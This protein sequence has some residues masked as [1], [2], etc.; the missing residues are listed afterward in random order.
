MIEVA[1]VLLP[2]IGALIAGLFGRL[3]G[4]RGAQ[5]VTCSLLGLSA[6]L[7]MVIFQDIALAGNT[8]V[9]EIFTWI[10]SGNLELSW[11]VKLD[12]LSAVMLLN[13]LAEKEGD[14]RCRES[15]ARIRQAYDAALRM[16]ERTRD[17]GGELSTE[18][19]TDALVARL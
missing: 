16:G 4:D 10:D 5:I 15:A 3:I 14:E 19:F 8:R 7:S 17:I 18:E 11:A 12:T 2:L 6:V 1:I 9:T 13:H